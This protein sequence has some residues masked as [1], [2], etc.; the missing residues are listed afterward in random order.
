MDRRVTPPKL[1]G[2]AWGFFGLARKVIKV[3]ESRET[4]SFVACSCALQA[5]FCGFITQ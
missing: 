2:V 4:A 1:A 5:H 3:R